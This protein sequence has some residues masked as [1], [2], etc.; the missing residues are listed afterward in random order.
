MGFKLGSFIGGVAKGASESIEE[1][2]KLNT[3]SINASVK[4]MYHNYQEY[5]KEVEKKKET[6]RGTV[7]TLRG[8]KFE[9][10]PLDDEQLIALASNPKLAEQIADTLTKNP[11]KLVGLSKSFITSSNVPKG[12]KFDDFLNNY[13]KKA[14]LTSEEFAEAA[15]NKEEGFFNKMIYGNNLQKISSAA[16]QLGVKPEEL[17]A[18]GSSKGMPS[19]SASL[20]VD[21]AKLQD[22]P[23]F[24]KIESDAQIAMYRAKQ[25]GTEDD[26]AKAA[27]NLGHITFIKEFGNKKDKTQS[28]IEADYANQVIK[29]KQDGKPQEAAAKERELRDWQRLVANPALAGKTDA[30]KISQANLIVAASRTMESTLKNYLPPGSFITTSNP[31]GTTNIEVKD[32]ASSDKAAKGYAAGREV[33]IKEM[34]TNG[35][36][37]SDMHKNALMS[38]GVQFD[39]D[40]NAVN[41]KIQYGGEAAPAGTPQTPRPRGGPMAKPASVAPAAPVLEFKTEAE[42]EAAKLPKGTKIKVGG[43]LAEV[44]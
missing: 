38:A 22:K 8:L 28:Q 37:R 26:I 30:D 35:K 3:T 41:P 33:L 36:P 34:T 5:K 14:A 7:G 25:E 16:R 39:G 44:Q 23:D 31:D 6:L 13:G 27:A 19:Y 40:G 10:G 18:Y 15:S 29:L 4:S 32:L 9:D 21:Y 43:R 11:D 17:Y 20:E 24:K 2:E 1:L 42:V 12:Q